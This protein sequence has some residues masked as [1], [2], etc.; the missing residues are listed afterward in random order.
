MT[1][2]DL[3]PLD[4]STIQPHVDTLLATELSH[5]NVESWLQQ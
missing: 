3:N 4:W 2:S 1:Y 5:D